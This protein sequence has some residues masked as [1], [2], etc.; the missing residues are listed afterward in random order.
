MSSLD[1][2]SSNLSDGLIRNNVS[3]LSQH[4]DLLENR[5]LHNEEL[6][7]VSQIELKPLDQSSCSQRY[8][9]PVVRH[10]YFTPQVF[11]M[12]AAFLAML[13]S[14]AHLE[15]EVLFQPK[16]SHQITVYVQNRGTAGV[17]SGDQLKEG[18]KVQVE[19]KANQD[20][21]AFQGVVN[22]HNEILS[23]SD[24]QHYLHLES[25]ESRMFPFSLELT[26]PS[27]N[28]TLV[29]VTCL[30]DPSSYS[31]ETIQNILVG[32]GSEQNFSCEKKSYLLR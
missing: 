3:L 29:V 7:R 12:C 17:W 22:R 19:I 10:R 20:L 28:E 4:I 11:A 18:D 2:S 25:G 5:C 9:K 21:F 6:E 14:H 27:E 23:V 8:S 15:N 1:R 16:G 31:P 24:S 32:V 26:G 13:W 30:E